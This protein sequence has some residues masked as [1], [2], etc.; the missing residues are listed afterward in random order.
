[1]WSLFKRNPAAVA[2]AARAARHGQLLDVRTPQEFAE[3]HLRGAVNIP[4]SELHRRLSELGDRS[5]PLVVYC[6]SGRRS[7]V[8][9]AELRSSGFAE[10]HDLGAMSNWPG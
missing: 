7:A 6:R 10:V 4:L 1:M 5:R 8:A 2:A 9:A 3:G